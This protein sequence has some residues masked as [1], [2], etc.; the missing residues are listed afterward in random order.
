MTDNTTA[1]LVALVIN[2]VILLAFGAA[3]L[4]YACIV[5]SIIGLALSAV[6]ESGGGR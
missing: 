6:V 2:L 5:T 4:G 1:R 3:T